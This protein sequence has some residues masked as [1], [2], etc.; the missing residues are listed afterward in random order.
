[1]ENR[2]FVIGAQGSV[3]DGRSAPVDLGQIEQH[4][5]SINAALWALV[6]VIAPQ[7]QASQ[8]VAPPAQVDS[9]QPA[10]P[11]LPTGVQAAPGADW[12]SA[13]PAELYERLRA[14]RVAV[15]QNSALPKL[16]AEVSQ[17]AAL[18]AVRPPVGAAATAAGPVLDAGSKSAAETAALP[19][20]YRGPFLPSGPAPAATPAPASDPA[21]APR[22]P[23]PQFRGQDWRNADRP[24]RLLI[25]VKPVADAAMAE[26][27]AGL[28]AT[29]PGFSSV[30][31]LGATGDVCAFEVQYEGEL[32]RGI[33]VSQ[34]LK[35]VGASL[36]AGGDREFYLA[37]EGQLVG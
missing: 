7:A 33:A 4:L 36:V 25:S 34:A 28:L 31:P 16:A 15:A 19:D 11:A 20:G 1:M 9:G 21:P 17:V 2:L 6:A 8:P 37:I 22:Q 30:R 35:G 12:R 3:P 14:K 10:Q 27:V 29:A 23:L 5:A 26:R 13:V 18:L 24:G 32:P